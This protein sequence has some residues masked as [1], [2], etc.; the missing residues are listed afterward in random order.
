M[1]TRACAQPHRTTGA[2][3]GFLCLALACSSATD[4]QLL[5]WEGD[6]QPTGPAGPNGS[7]AMVS[8]Y[9]RTDAS[10]LIEGALADTTYAW[11]INRG[12]CAVEGT[13]VG[14]A[15]VYPALTTDEEGTETVDASIPG[16]L[17][18]G[19]TYAAR[20]LLPA[21]AGNVVACGDLSR[22]R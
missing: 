8:Q 21:E 6:L 13:I 14:G 11:R 1:R 10:I 4:V 7:V 17:D 12:T 18:A 9:G 16:S 5:A 20:V 2:A 3:L 15:A 19:S 22:V